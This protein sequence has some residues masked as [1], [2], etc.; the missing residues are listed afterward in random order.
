LAG[1]VRTVIFDSQIITLI[2][3]SNSGSVGLK[4]FSALL[5]GIVIW[6]SR[7]G[8]IWQGLSFGKVGM[9]GFGRDCHL[10]K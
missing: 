1:I 8:W 3:N 4:A 9:V 2:F 6:E 10:G 7:D 5:L